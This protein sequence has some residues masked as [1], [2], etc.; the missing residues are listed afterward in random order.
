MK[1]ALQI[2]IRADCP[3]CG[4]RDYRNNGSSG[5]VIYRKCQSCGHSGKVHRLTQAELTE[6]LRRGEIDPKTVNAT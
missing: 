6:M 5:Q 2:E 4:A 3:K 1:Q